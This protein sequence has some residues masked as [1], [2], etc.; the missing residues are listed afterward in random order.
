M[1]DEKG[2]FL[3]GNLGNPGG[4]PKSDVQFKEILTAKTPEVLARL[5]QLTK[6]PREQI[7]LKAI[8]IALS[9]SLSKPKQE[10][11]VELTGTNGGYIGIDCPRSLTEQEWLERRKQDLLAKS[12]Q[13]T[14]GSN[15][16]TN[17]TT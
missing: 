1:R 6:H 12:I 14:N 16:H 7:A 13:H 11:S 15:G 9:Y 8:E 5:L 3:K 10:T 17:G 4:R 2:Q